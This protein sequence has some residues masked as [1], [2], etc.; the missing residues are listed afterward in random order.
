[1]AL[2]AALTTPTEATRVNAEATEKMGA[3]ATASRS[4]ERF[5]LKRISER[6]ENGLKRLRSGIRIEWLVIAAYWVRNSPAPQRDGGHSAL[7]AFRL[8]HGR[9]H[10]H[11]LDIVPAEFFMYRHI[12]GKWACRCCRCLVQESAQ[13]QIID[14]GMPVRPGSQRTR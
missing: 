7:F 1:M 6:V 9:S 5:A 10:C 11:R 14:G 2:E 13:P 8:S 12:Y 3:D 4:A